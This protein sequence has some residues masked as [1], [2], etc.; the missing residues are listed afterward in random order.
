MPSHHPNDSNMSP[1]ATSRP[2]PPRVGRLR[3]DDRPVTSPRPARHNPARRHLGTS[4]CT[5]MRP[6]HLPHI[7]TSAGCH[8]HTCGPATYRTS[9]RP[10]VAMSTHAA[11]P[12]PAR[13]H[14]HTSAGCHVH[15]CGPAASRAA[16]REPASPAYG[17]PASSNCRFVSTAPNRTSGSWVSSPLS[18]VVSAPARTGGSGGELINA[19]NV[20]C[21]DG[22]L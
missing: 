15:T 7:R 11:R 18:T 6:A 5:H 12:P 13:P 1:P 17:R 3:P 20:A 21:T 2:R 16:A 22:R 8:V 14:I 4:T 10:Q 19:V 9:A